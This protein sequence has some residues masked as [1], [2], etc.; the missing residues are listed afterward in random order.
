MVLPT[1]LRSIHILLFDLKDEERRGIVKA[2]PRVGEDVYTYIVGLT[3]RTKLF[4][5]WNAKKALPI[6]L[7]KQPAPTKMEVDQLQ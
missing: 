3:W 4:K 2:E 1:Q 6:Q 7:L 5:M